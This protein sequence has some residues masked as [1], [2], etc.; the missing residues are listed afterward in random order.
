MATEAPATPVPVPSTE[1]EPVGGVS[2]TPRS[3]GVSRRNSKDVPEL[4]EQAKIVLQTIEKLAQQAKDAE[5]HKE[6]LEKLASKGLLEDL[7]PRLQERNRRHSKD[8]TDQIAELQGANLEAIFKKFD[9]DNSGALD[10]DEL[11]AAY[12]AAGMNISDEN[13]R[14]TIK[15]LDTNGDGEID[16][17][18]RNTRTP[19]APLPRVW[20][21]CSP[22]AHEL[23]PPS[24]AAGVQGDCAQ[25]RH[26]VERLKPCDAAQ[27]VE[28]RGGRHYEIRGRHTEGVI[29]MNNRVLFWH[30]LA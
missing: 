25:G 4:D 30:D 19:R 17:E 23:A 12:R 20:A 27:C 1:A 9:T 7:T 28:S 26:A 8:L 10:A 2:T 3:R 15:M 21:R 18:V 22:A 13:L 6:R 14:K 16:L 11:T 29:G 5:E 24:R